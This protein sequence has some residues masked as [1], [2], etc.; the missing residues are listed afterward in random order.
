MAES[1]ISK[2]PEKP[3]KAAS[4]YATTQLFAAVYRPIL[5]DLAQL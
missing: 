4:A 3:A 2:A 5:A 1:R